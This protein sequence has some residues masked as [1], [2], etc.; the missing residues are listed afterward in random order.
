[1]DEK[2]KKALDFSNFN[3]TFTAKRENIREKLESRLIYGQ[4][5]GIFKIDH[6]LITFIQMLIDKGRKT[7]VPIID[8]NRNPILIP[9]LEKFRDEIFDRYFQALGD[10]FAEYE[11]IKSSRTVEKLV[12]Y[13]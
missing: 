10:Y 6:T 1:M 3:K 4:S 13:E 12:E 8:S 5:G 7:Q 9:D 2:L 11:K